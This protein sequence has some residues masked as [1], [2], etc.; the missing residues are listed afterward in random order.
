M[1]VLRH[2]IHRGKAMPGFALTKPR[3]NR[4]CLAGCSPLQVQLNASVVS[5]GTATVSTG[6]A[7][8]YFATWKSV[9]FPNGSKR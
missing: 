1:Y 6:T 7:G 3:V 4:H 8:L 2:D 9:Q 5:S